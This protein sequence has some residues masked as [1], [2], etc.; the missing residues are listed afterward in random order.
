[1][2]LIKYETAPELQD[3]LGPGIL[4]RRRKPNLYEWVGKSPE[5]SRQPQRQ[6]FAGMAWLTS[7]TWWTSL[8]GADR[9]SWF[10]NSIL[11]HH[12]RPGLNGT[13]MGNQPFSRF[14]TNVGPDTY[15]HT[16]PTLK[17]QSYGD[18]IVSNLRVDTYHAPWQTVTIAFDLQEGTPP[19]NPYQFHV[20]QRR[21]GA[22]GFTDTWHH[23]KIAKSVTLTD[24]KIKTYF[25]TTTLP[26]RQP[27][28]GCLALYVRA[29]D[30]HSCR[31]YDLTLCKYP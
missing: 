25:V 21:P 14:I 4:R 19:T 6:A 8:T 5:P 31:G 2:A 20:Y 18:C 1:M 22:Y 7:L 16:T 17:A 13:N 26:Y 28:V 23:W 15:Y 10:D 3:E 11:V 12:Q 24:P 29:R 27:P 30:A 9:L